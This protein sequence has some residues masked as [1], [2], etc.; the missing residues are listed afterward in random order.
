MHGDREPLAFLFAW[1]ELASKDP[2]MTRDEHCKRGL[3][4]SPEDVARFAFR[5]RKHAG[6]V[7]AAIRAAGASE[8]DSNNTTNIEH[9]KLSYTL[10]FP[11]ILIK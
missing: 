7:W 1:N 9:C 2:S 3:K 11:C 8:S 10:F 5:V 4:L 6:P